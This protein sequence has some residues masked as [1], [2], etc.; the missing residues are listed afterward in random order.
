MALYVHLFHLCCIYLYINLLNDPC[1]LSSLEFFNEIYVHLSHDL[2][3]VTTWVLRPDVHE[4]LYIY[5]LHRNILYIVYT[6]IVTAVYNC[7][8]LKL[9]EIC[10]SVNTR[11]LFVLLTN[12]ESLHPQVNF[13][14]FLSLV[15]QRAL[16][17]EILEGSFDKSP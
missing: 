17:L 6:F 9:L 7:G 3:V 5:L 1:V 11:C 14:P 2:C 8:W 15:V 10:I 4:A 12:I 13:N 16:E